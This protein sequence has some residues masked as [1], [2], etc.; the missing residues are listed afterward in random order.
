MDAQKQGKLNRARKPR[1]DE[2]GGFF[3]TEK[4][5]MTED[6]VR[7]TLVR[8]AHEIVENNGGCNDLIFIGIHTRGVPLARR[9]A[10]EIAK[11]EQVNIPVGA[12]DIGLHRDDLA[13]L[14]VK[15]I[16]RPSDIPADI[17]GKRVILFDDVL[18]TGRSV[19]A[20]MDALVDF[21]RPQR[22]LLAV[23][24]DRGHRELPIKANFVGKNIPSSQYERVQLRLEETDGK[25]E[26]VIL[27]L[28][29]IGTVGALQKS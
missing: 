25:D 5:I 17:T 12:L 6:E 11:F 10:A 14:G 16:I 22:V 8:I 29:R 3:V 15:P 7:R 27:G 13:F 21:G 9:M 23:L 19:R 26:V 18:F 20:A 28:A 24:I 4:V 1:P 2:G